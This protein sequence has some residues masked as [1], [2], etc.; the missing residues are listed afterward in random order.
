MFHGTTT[1]AASKVGSWAQ[2][3]TCMMH[4]SIAE[5]LQ[6]HVAVVISVQMV[7]VVASW[8]SMMHCVPAVIHHNTA[9]MTLTCTA[10]S[11]TG[12]LRQL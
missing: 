6:C 5:A 7:T 9:C 4:V 3:I 2:H 1:L 12:I 10:D 8:A 11:K